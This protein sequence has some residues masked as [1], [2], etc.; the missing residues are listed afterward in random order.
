[1]FVLAGTYPRKRPEEKIIYYTDEDYFTSKVLNL[2]QSCTIHYSKLQRN[3][4]NELSKSKWRDI[5]GIS[6]SVMYIPVKYGDDIMG[7]LR[8]TNEFNINRNPF[9]NFIDIHFA[10]TFSSLMFTWLKTARAQEQYS[11]SLLDITHDIKLIAA[12]IKS[13]AQ[14]VI[15]EIENPKNPNSEKIFKLS[16]IR[17]SA[18]SLIELLRELITR[19]GIVKVDVD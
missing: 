9:F 19:Q 5:D 10:E 16:H 1:M 17:H 8:C 11:F 3:Q 6:L 14:F 4:I 13:A 2:E 15:N 18:D 7:L 12:G